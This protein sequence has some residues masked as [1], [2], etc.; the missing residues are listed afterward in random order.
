MQ[1]RQSD[2]DTLAGVSGTVPAVA[3]AS[4]DAWLPVRAPSRPAPA[5]MAAEAPDTSTSRLEN[6]LATR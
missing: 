1:D 5:P 4:A 3:R 6:L 2:G